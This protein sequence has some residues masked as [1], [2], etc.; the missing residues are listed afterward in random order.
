MLEAHQQFRSPKR[1]ISASMSARILCRGR[2]LENTASLSVTCLIT[3]CHSSDESASHATLCFFLLTA[4]AVADA[5]LLIRTSSPQKKNWHLSARTDR[6][7]PWSFFWFGEGEGEG[8]FKNQNHRFASIG[9]PP[10]H[11]SMKEVSGEFVL[12]AC[13][14]A[15]VCRA[16][17]GAVLAVVGASWLAWLLLPRS[18]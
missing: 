6:Q 7:N 10:G 17:A 14:C 1:A 13:L 18:R 12:R 16:V 5:A 8:E 4:C 9:R 2:C 15:C 3:Q 11:F